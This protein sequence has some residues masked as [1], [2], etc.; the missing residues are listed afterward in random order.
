MR[1]DVVASH[2]FLEHTSEVEL[3]LR[4][5]SLDELVAEAGRAL[6]ELMLRC[7]KDLSGDTHFDV[8]LHSRDEAALLV[9]W[10]NELV[11]LAESQKW[12]PRESE[13]VHIGR[14]TSGEGMTLRARMGGVLLEHAPSEV[15]AATFHGLRVQRDAEGIVANVIL[16][17]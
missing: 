13:S 15:K 17:V 5:S 16:D 11:Y 7:R 4:A 12:A 9:D 2:E 6:G 14:D 10:L 3:H 8:E 1:P